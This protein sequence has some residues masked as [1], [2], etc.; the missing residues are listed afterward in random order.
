[1][2][3][4]SASVLTAHLDRVRR[5]ETVADAL[6][7]DVELRGAVGLAAA[8]ELIASDEAQTYHDVRDTRLREI[9]FAT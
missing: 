3:D 7:L 2:R 4:V 8:L 6:A 9:V 1:M 5:A